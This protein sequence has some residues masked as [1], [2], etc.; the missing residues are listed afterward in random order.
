MGAGAGR[1]GLDDDLQGAD[2]WKPDPHLSVI[3]DDRYE[4]VV[5]VR[6]AHDDSGASKDMERSDGVG[7]AA[8]VARPDRGRDLYREHLLEKTSDRVAVQ[9]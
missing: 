7:R 6:A 1:G 3:F 8:A 9:H 4:G 5:A 2:S